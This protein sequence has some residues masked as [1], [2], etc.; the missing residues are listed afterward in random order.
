[1]RLPESDAWR[2]AVALAIGLLMGAEREKRKAQAPQRLAAGIRTFAIVALLGG[3]AGLIGGTAI[4]TLFGALVGGAAIVAYGLGDRADPGQTTEL[5]LILDYGLGVLAHERPELAFALAVTA[6]ALLAFRT[7]LHE[8]V[9]EV[10]SEEELLDLVIFG[11]AA[12]VVWPL[13]P[14]RSVD[15]LGVINLFVLWRLVILVMAVTGL[16]YVAQRLI[17]PRWGLAVAGL[18]GGFASSA[19]TIHTM[20]TLARTDPASRR[21][22]VAGA[23]ASSIATFALMASI[24]A[25]ASPRLFLRAALPLALGGF[26]AL[27]FAAVEILRAARAPAPASEA[28]RAFSLRTAVLFALTV[29]VVIFT[30]ALLQR[31]IGAGGALVAAAAGA[32]A[33]A[34]AAAASVAALEAGDQLPTSL[35]VFGILISLTTNAVTKIVIAFTAGPRS[36]AL[37]IALGQ[38]L[39]IGAAW[40]AMSLAGP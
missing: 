24:V 38:V 3:V 37:Q 9:R 29:A 5:A 35:A 30:A 20:G 6:T 7:R 11:V 36:F 12:V 21:A 15:P 33:D 13:L 39:A 1:M 17:G 16:G 27:V 10:L 28:R 4:I 19:A 2:L 22:A 31:L 18:A 34:H 25:A 23:A 32:F 26:T 8:V 14:D 40:A